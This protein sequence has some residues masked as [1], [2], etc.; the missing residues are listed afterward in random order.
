L[1]ETNTE[2][3]MAATQVRQLMAS[4]N[5]EMGWPDD[6][7]LELVAPEPWR[8]NI[9]L[10]EVSDRPLAANPDVIEVEQTVVKA[11]ATS[12]ISKLESVPVATAVSGYLFQNAI[13]AVPSNFGY[14][15]VVASYNL[16]DL[17]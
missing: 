7:E 6:T 15:G 2:F 5:R 1:V 11:R 14:G 4:L 8:E 17:L 3:V 9:T 12:A 13:P 10:E 16:F